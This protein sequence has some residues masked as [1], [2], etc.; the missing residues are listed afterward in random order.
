MLVPDH[1]NADGLWVSTYY[2]GKVQCYTK[3]WSLWTGINKRCLIGGYTQSNQPSYIG[4]TNEFENFQYFAEWCQSQ[5]GYCFKGYQLDKDVLIKGNKIY[6]PDT[7]VFIPQELNSLLN[8]R[9]NDR[10]C[11]PIGVTFEKDRGTFSAQIN[12]GT[13]RKRIRGFTDPISAYECYK[14]HKEARIKEMAQKYKNYID[15]RVFIALMQYTVE[16]ND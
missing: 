4:C 6:S 8:K 10:G 16:I 5:I 14:Q 11:L 15:Q 7:C 13:A 1:K 2:Q 12:T 3:S 9:Q